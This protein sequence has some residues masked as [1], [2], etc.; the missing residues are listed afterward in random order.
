MPSISPLVKVDSDSAI[1]RPNT[2]FRSRL[3]VTHLAV[4][5]AVAGNLPSLL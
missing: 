1:T 2:L 3:I 4:A 5:L